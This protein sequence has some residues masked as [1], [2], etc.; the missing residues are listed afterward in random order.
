M[1]FPTP[2][3]VREDE[4]LF[5]KTKLLHFLKPEHLDIPSEYCDETLWIVAQQELLNINMY[6][7]P[8]D[9]L[10]CIVKACKTIF[11]ATQM[12]CK[13]E[14]VSADIFLP[15]LIH[16]VVIANPPSL[17]SN[18]RYV[19]YFRH[20]G[21]MR[22]ESGYYFVSFSTAVYFIEQM[23]AQSLSIDPQEYN[24]Y[25][26]S[27]EQ[28]VEPKPTEKEKKYTP[29]SLN[30]HLLYSCAAGDLETIQYLLNES[31]ADPNFVSTTPGK[32]LI[33]RL[34]DT[35]VSVACRIGNLEVVQYLIKH[36]KVNI[37]MVFQDG[38][39]IL[40]REC[41]GHKL[42][43]ELLFNLEIIQLLIDNGADIFLEDKQ[44]NSPLVYA[45]RSGIVH[46]LN[47]KYDQEHL[48]NLMDSKFFGI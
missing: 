38:K 36:S 42:G 43:K 30:D 4:R 5:E 33:I 6:K 16:N 3:Y 9:K 19:Q 12:L 35:P 2:Q 37:N 15:I 28:N 41:A 39:T 34:G 10:M 40:H 14:P 47:V 24:R 48:I 11:S 20:P 45:K 26:G 17:K 13:G 46:L 1:F 7:S 22:H 21:A 8:R 23:N 27:I 31:G 32:S 29:Y 25:M 44:G 18:V